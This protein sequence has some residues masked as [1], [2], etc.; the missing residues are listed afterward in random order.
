MKKTIFFFI[1]ISLS[2]IIGF[3]CSTK[4]TP[5]SPSDP[6]SAVSIIPPSRKYI[7][8]HSQDVI[9]YAIEGAI[10]GGIISIS[11]AYPRIE[12]TWNSNSGNTEI[13]GRYQRTNNVKFID[14]GAKWLITGINDKTNG[15]FTNTEI[16]FVGTEYYYWYYSTN[17]IVEITSYGFV[18]NDIFN[19]FI[20]GT[21]SGTIEAYPGDPDNNLPVASLIL[22]DGYFSAPSSRVTPTTNTN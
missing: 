14:A 5:I 16:Y 6:G 21:F 4:D 3:S 10:G 7:T 8:K 17:N 20:I 9:G 1:I 13:I 12:G 2:L 19:I 18:D 22:S 15:S 11:G